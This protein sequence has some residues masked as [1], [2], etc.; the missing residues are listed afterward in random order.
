[1]MVRILTVLL[2]VSIQLQ[3]QNKSIVRL[4]NS[5]NLSGTVI[6]GESVRNFVGNVQIENEGSL[7]FA[8]RMAKYEVRNFWDATGNVKLIDKGVTL[9]SEFAKYFPDEKRSQFRSKV[10]LIS[11]SNDLFSDFGTYNMESRIA[12]FWGNTKLI[13]AEKNIIYSDSITHYENEN[14]SILKSKVK[15]INQSDRTVITGGYAEYFG[16]RKFS[17]VNRM[18]FLYQYPEK[19]SSDTLFVIGKYM[20]SYQGDIQRYSVFGNVR[21]LNGL[22][23]AKAD[24]LVMLRNQNLMKLRNNPIVWFESTQ[25]SGDSIDIYTENNE[26]RVINCYGSS[27]AVS[28]LDSMPNKYNQLKGKTISYKFRNKVIYQIDVHLT[29]ESIYYLDEEGEPAGANVSSGDEMTIYFVNG[30]VDRI[31][32]VGGIEGKFL[33]E[34]V[35]RRDPVF[36]RGFYWADNIRPLLGEMRNYVR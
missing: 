9:T 17:F 23:S 26:L 11:D 2:F 29:A 3:A 20:E 27:I 6:N 31:K 16:D 21:V 12:E 36:L 24:T 25:I 14:H 7:L 35:V 32:I 30:L 1:M 19:G 15:I 13:D 8:D 28:A 34:S 5:D 10:H 22:M 33:P 18:P 4:L